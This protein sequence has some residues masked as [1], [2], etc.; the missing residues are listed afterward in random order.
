[1]PL[2]T[3]KKESSIFQSTLVLVFI[4][5]FT[6]K[7]RRRRRERRRRSDVNDVNDDDL[8]FSFSSRLCPRR[9]RVVGDAVE[10]R[11]RRDIRRS[12]RRIGFREEDDDGREE[13]K[14][15]PLTDNSKRP[16]LALGCIRR[17]RETRVFRQKRPGCSLRERA[18]RV[19]RSERE[20][21]KTLGRVR[22][23]DKEDEERRR[24]RRR[25]LT[26][27]EN[28]FERASRDRAKHAGGVCE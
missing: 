12:R 21:F 23:I 27:L 1:M 11:L 16:I 9:F 24:K 18:E 28:V 22:D 10:R 8:F 26:Q 15:S 20:K 2:F 25:V 4:H 6:L 13:E 19:P 7:R 5:L 14:S 3:S 17:N